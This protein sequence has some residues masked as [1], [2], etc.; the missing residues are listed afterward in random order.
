[1][2]RP[3]MPAY[4]P[5]AQMARPNY[6][7]SRPA[8]PAYRAPMNQMARPA[9]PAYRAP[10]NQMNRPNYATS[11]PAYRAPMNQMVRPTQGG[12]NRPYVGGNLAGA[13]GY[14]API[15]ANQGLY[16]P[17]VVG[18]GA[19]LGRN[20]PGITANRFGPGGALGT[21][22]GN[23][24][25][26]GRVGNNFVGNNAYG[27]NN[28]YAGGR[29]GLAGG[30]VGRTVIN[31][32]NTNIVNGGY[33]GGYGNGNGFG[34][35]RGYGGYGGSGNWNQPYYGNWY[36]GNSFGSGFGLGALAGFGLS[37]LGYGGSGGY[38]YGGYGNGF[39]YGGGY[40]NG[41]GNG[42][43]NVYASPLYSGYGA[44]NVLPAW[45][46]SNYNSWGLGSVANN[47]LYS[48]YSN[49]YYS[50][51][52]VS[53]PSYASTAV[54][55]YSQPINL[56]SAPPEA[57]VVDSTEQIFSSARDAFKAG[58]YPRSL[59]LADE[60]LKQT[61]NVPVV[62]EFR[63][64][65]LFAMGRYEEASAVE[66]A[67]LSAGPGWDWATMVGLYPNVDTYTN[68]L[69][70]LEAFAKTNPSSTSAQFLLAD[71]YLVMGHIDSA[72]LEFT[73]VLALQPNETLSASFL[74]LLTK[75]PEPTA[76]G[77]PTASA[78]LNTENPLGAPGLPATNYSTTPPASPPTPAVRPADTAP[79]L[80]PPP[81]DF[82][83]TWKAKPTADVSITLTIQAGGAFV[84]ELDNKGQKQTLQ[85][86]AGYQDGTLALQQP[87]GP[88]LVGKVTHDRADLFTFA[89]PGGTAEKPAVLTFTR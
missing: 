76:S 65:A 84:W 15:G 12:I 42:Y 20:Y 6:A 41:F 59:T 75:A 36:R 64:L 30:G 70:A 74:K 38:G 48:G 58:D 61:P 50:S 45:G 69:R 87:N 80:P 67:V 23:Q 13:G 10:V 29:N 17:G 8:M 54:Y 83:G 39:G 18:N 16:R 52:V 28:P 63:A 79:A 62:H 4:R 72:K 71:H 68:Q 3:S 43:G 47:W 73:R 51:V 44:Y 88:P 82:M 7:T 21:A 37:S 57:T 78:P 85:G 22:Y 40:G 66:Y 1:M 89:P 46:A 60:V 11:R 25:G 77:L 53:Q 5:Q 34:Y 2:M 33:G 35:S 19:A 55:D 9:M 81:A 49:P 86:T 31:N 26:T 14:R 56:T 24:L 32:N 27:G